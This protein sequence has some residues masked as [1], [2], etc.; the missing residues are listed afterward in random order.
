[1]GGSRRVVKY[2]YQCPQCLNNTEFLTRR[3]KGRKCR[4]CHIP[5]VYKPKKY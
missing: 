4:K 3:D 1:M 2:L 5:I